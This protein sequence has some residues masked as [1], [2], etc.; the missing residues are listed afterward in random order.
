MP[1][2]KLYGIARVNYD[3]TPWLP[4]VFQHVEREYETN[5]AKI[6]ADMESVPQEVSEKGDLTTTVQQV[7]LLYKKV[8]RSF[9]QL[10]VHQD[11]YQIAF[12]HFTPVF[13]RVTKRDFTMITGKERDYE[14][15]EARLA[16][17]QRN[18]G[19]IQGR[20]QDFKDKLVVFEGQI[21]PLIA[22]EN[23]KQGPVYFKMPFL[24]KDPLEPLREAAKDDPLEFQKNFAQALQQKTNEPEWEGDLEGV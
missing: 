19:R 14:V 5:K 4:N 10:G 22:R 1:A 3:T 21:R 7:S 16:L 12:N 9:L 8:Y 18:L 23:S 17:L 11:E 13:Q 20:Y 15:Q 24:G 6:K 2:V